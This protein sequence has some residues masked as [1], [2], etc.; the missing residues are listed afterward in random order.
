L[1]ESNYYPHASDD[2]DSSAK[3]GGG[4]DAAIDL[5]G[6]FRIAPQPRAA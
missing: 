5:D 1:G 3:R 6:F 4:M 2:C